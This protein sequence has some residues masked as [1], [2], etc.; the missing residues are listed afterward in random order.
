[1]SHVLD[2]MLDIC[3]GGYFFIPGH[4]KGSSLGVV[5]IQWRKLKARVNSIVP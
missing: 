4:L 3:D 2:K 1:M 5:I